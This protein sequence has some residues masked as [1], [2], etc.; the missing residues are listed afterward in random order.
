MIYVNY[1]DDTEGKNPISEVVL[2]ALGSFN[3]VACSLTLP[4]F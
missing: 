1:Y 2:I 3:H 4:P